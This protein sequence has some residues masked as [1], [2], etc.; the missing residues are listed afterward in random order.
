MTLLVLTF[1]L[2]H[3]RHPGQFIMVSV[4]QVSINIGHSGLKAEE[5]REKKKGD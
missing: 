1:F 4:A 3:L 2:N 5:Q